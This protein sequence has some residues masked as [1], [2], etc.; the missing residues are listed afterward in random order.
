MVF[1]QQRQLKSR[2]WFFCGMFAVR[3]RWR[4]RKMIRALTLS[5]PALPQYLLARSH[6]TLGKLALRRIPFLPKFSVPASV[7]I[8]FLTGGVTRA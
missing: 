8:P 2:L 7:R 6:E 5:V 1:P 3:C 4:P